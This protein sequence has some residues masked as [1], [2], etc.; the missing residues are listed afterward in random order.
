MGRLPAGCVFVM[1]DGIRSIFHGLIRPAKELACLVSGSPSPGA[2]KSGMGC[3][4]ERENRQKSDPLG[5][6]PVARTAVSNRRKL[7]TSPG[8]EAGLGG[9]QN[10]GRGR[11]TPTEDCYFL[12]PSLPTDRILECMDTV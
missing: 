3:E 6:H 10:R 4:R 5:C 11:Q 2:R 8:V 7:P 1:G 9:V 12:P